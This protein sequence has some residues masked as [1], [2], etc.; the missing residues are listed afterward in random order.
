MT[1]PD[2]QTLMRP[3]L[4]YLVDGQQKS[5]STVTDAIG[6]RQVVGPL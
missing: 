6:L 3:I 5:T 4:A 1:I 2:F